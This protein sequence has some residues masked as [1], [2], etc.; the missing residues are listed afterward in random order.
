MGKFKFSGKWFLYVVMKISNS[1]KKMVRM[2][3]C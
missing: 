2:D 1:K 3:F